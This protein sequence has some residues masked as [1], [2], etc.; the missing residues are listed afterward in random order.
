MMESVNPATEERLRVYDEW[1]DAEVENALAGASDAW[2]VWRKTSFNHRADLMRRAARVLR[3]RRDEYARIATLEMGKPITGARAE[4]EKCALGCD[5]YADTAA[6]HLAAETIKTDA[7]RSYV[8]YDPLGVVLAIMPWNFPFW[9]VFRFAAPALMAG[10]GGVLKHASNVTGCALAIEDVFKRAGFPKNIFRTLLIGASR[11]KS[12]ISDDRIA[13]AT[14]TGS[15]RA[16]VAVG[17]QAGGALK[18]SVLELGGSDP[19]IVLADADV[20]TAAKVGA[21]ARTVNSGQSCIAAKRFIVVESVWD[22]FT[23]A[24]T[25]HMRA[26]Q[27]GDPLDEKTEIGPQARSDLRDELH[28]QVKRS[29]S[30]GARALA[31]GEP[32]KGKGYFY[33]PTVLVDVGRGMPAYE[34]ELFGPV[35]SVIR[36]KDTEEA[37][38]V[39]NDSRFGLGSSLWTADISLAES[40]AARIEAGCVFVNSL[41]KSDPRL[42]FGGIKK[43]GY[44]RELSRHGIQ[45][46]ANAK[47]VWIQS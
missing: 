5:Y 38:E 41:V 6:A 17:S 18:P 22:N 32:V 2:K 8:R 39:A 40:L 26:L 43:S 34:E 13:A 44:G 20:A 46:F 36:V 4:V 11:V 10:N 7:A 24:F 16:G 25:D 47:S 35:A 19:F 14:L 28:E 42:P 33:P 29:V 27:M 23:N 31:G 12:V 21:Q 3:E 45:A 9:Q 37:V 15:E 30:A 1:T